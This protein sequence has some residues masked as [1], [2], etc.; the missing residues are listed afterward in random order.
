MT[1]AQTQTQ[2][3]EPTEPSVESPTETKPYSGTRTEAE[4][5]KL[6]YE[7]P[8]KYGLDDAAAVYQ[9]LNNAVAVL[10]QGD[11]ENLLKA[12][13]E[14][15]FTKEGKK[16][17]KS[18]E[19]AF[20]NAIERMI[21]SGDITT[22]AL[23]YDLRIAQTQQK[24]QFQNQH[25]AELQKLDTPNDA[26]VQEIDALK[27]DIAN[28]QYF[29]KSSQKSRLEEC[30]RTQSVTIQEEEKGLDGKGTGKMLNVTKTE[31]I[32]VANAVLMFAERFIDGPQTEEQ[33]NEI[34]KD[35]LG[36]IHKT[37]QDAFNERHTYS[38]TIDSKGDFIETTKDKDG[39]VQRA[40]DANGDL[41]L[42][43][44][45]KKAL[46]GHLPNELKQSL[47]NTY[48]ELFTNQWLVMCLKLLAY[49]IGKEALKKMQQ[50]A[51]GGLEGGLGLG[52]KKR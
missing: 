48:K 10:K 35:P 8:G 19:A 51:Q 4:L 26:Q 41:K 31:N 27:M 34:R 28:T 2:I 43:A 9:T 46:N 20:Q 40:R 12:I 36:H 11:A 30:R 22:K 38:S 32:P 44:L 50:I 29:L 33:I 1:E 17:M 39:N 42:E 15:P 24:L 52:A 25:L 7:H 16:V 37:L 13:T 6:R 21:G 47:T 5:T 14:L 3:E 45:V 18:T 49:S 23:G